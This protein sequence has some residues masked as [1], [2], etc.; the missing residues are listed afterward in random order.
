M[1]ATLQEILEAR[2]RRAEKQAQL[3]KTFG[4]T[5]ICFTMNIPGPVKYDDLIAK[6]FALGCE[7]LEAQLTGA[8]IAV[9]FR[10]KL[11][12]H[13]GCEAFYVVDA[14]A[15]Q[16]KS[17]A[18]AIE[19]GSELGR[20]FD[21][22][23]LDSSGRKLSRET[24]RKCLLCENSA[25][26]CGPRRAHSVEQLQARTRA[27]LQ[28]AVWQHQSR[29]VGAMAAKALLYEVCTTP[30]PGLVDR[31]NNG[32][33]ADMD[34]FTF[35][36]STAALQ[37]YFTDCA[38][39]GLETAQLDPSATFDRLRYL[40]RNAEQTM[41]CATGGA[42]THKGAIFTLG[43]LCGAAGRLEEEGRADP[44]KVLSQ[45]A[46]M[47]KDLTAELSGI[48]ED[49]AKTAG[50]R[51]YVRYG[52][53]GIRGQA[54]AGY[55]AVLHTGL[56]VLEE[57]LALGYSLERSGCAALLAML[58]AHTDTNLVSRSDRETAKRI[59]R[60]VA[61][62]LAQNRYPETE[63]LQALDEVFIS[64]NLSLG[65]TADLL[66]ACYFLHFLKA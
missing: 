3:L 50:Q 5:L 17:L 34:I 25:R 33:H 24:D 44:E 52:I 59:S 13:T 54:E 10:E 51:L 18:A 11:P 27:I 41:L 21:M 23:V 57:G 39:A 56:P 60:E 15:E 48:T 14:P 47:C 31:A 49:T 22:D 58:T 37:P 40:G 9:R 7:T 1:E 32:S 65:G 19:E 20:L 64:K 26:V 36:A 53:T 63:T 42:N 62:L 2:E 16:V 28:E 4:C 29:A 66:A 8:E 35:L 46:A 6:G 43:L 61:L 45:C 55:P 38:R 30:K 12:R